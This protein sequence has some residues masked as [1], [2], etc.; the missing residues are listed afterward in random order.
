MKRKWACLHNGVKI[1]N[2]YVKWGKEF[3]IDWM[4]IVKLVRRDTFY[5]AI[6]TI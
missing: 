6:E 4:G 1:E 2:C 5:F 3:C